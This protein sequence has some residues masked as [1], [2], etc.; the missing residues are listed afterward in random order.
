MASDGSQVFV[1]GGALSLDILVDEAKP[2]H[3]LD[4]SMYFPFV[5]SF[6][7]PPRPK[8][9][10]QLDYSKPDSNE[11]NPSE[12]TTQL[13]RKSSAGRLTQGQPHEQTSLDAR[14]ARGSP[15]F[16]RATPEKLD[17][18]A[19]LQITHER[20]VELERKQSA[21]LAAQTERDQRM[22]Q[23][24]DG[25]ERKLSAVLATQTERDRRIAQLT[26][27]LAQ[28]RTLLKQAEANA[29]EGKKRA[30]LELRELQAKLDK[31]VLSCDHALEQAQSALQATSRTAEANEQSQ[32][33]LAEVRAELEASKSESATVHLRRKD[34]ESG[35]A[36]HN[37]EADTSDANIA[38]NLVNTDED[39]VMRRLME[40]MRAMEG[41]IAS[42]RG[43]EKSFEM[44]EHRNEG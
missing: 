2:I 14:A 44:M 17:N 37:A 42:L 15:S 11:V 19:S 29:V 4:T 5:I 28:T 32:R 31:L 34:A 21:M 10:E 18:P 41:E 27:E 20:L 22:A 9:A 23:L 1:L 6:G 35:W 13:A 25:L 16:Q 33:E 39:G 26:D 36:K 12:K 43:N 8:N 7:W 38:A 3:V 30:E 24:T 40:R